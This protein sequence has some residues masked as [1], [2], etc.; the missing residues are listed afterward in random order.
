MSELLKDGRIKQ[1]SD[2]LKI[3]EDRI[4]LLESQLKD[5][6]AQHKL[7]IEYYN[8]S[9]DDLKSTSDV[10]KKEI[11][12]IKKDNCRISA[13]NLT[14][15][16]QQNDIIDENNLLKEQTAKLS[17]RIESL[18]NHIDDFT[19]ENENLSKTNKTLLAEISTLKNMSNIENK[20]SVIDPRIGFHPL[21]NDAVITMTYGARAY[22]TDVFPG[23]LWRNGYWY[24]ITQSINFTPMSNASIYSRLQKQYYDGPIRFATEI[25]THAILINDTFD[26]IWVDGVRLFARRDVKPTTNSADT[27]ITGIQQTPGITVKEVLDSYRD[28]YVP[29]TGKLH[30][31]TSD[32]LYSDQIVV[33]HSYIPK[34][35]FSEYDVD[36]TSNWH[37]FSA[38]PGKSYIYQINAY[39]SQNKRGRKIFITDQQKTEIQQRGFLYIKDIVYQTNT[40]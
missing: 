36:P 35:Y 14:L 17:E 19:K 30:S 23:Y 33:E 11:E 24:K 13:I 1:L 39:D 4:S 5:I 40:C 9:I 20:T 26:A 3:K 15:E 31:G 25:P 6:I 21:P 38:E 27:S 2:E 29:A 10:Y 12:S 8:K 37:L 16:N 22:I 34:K 28:F 7:D 18:K 32:S